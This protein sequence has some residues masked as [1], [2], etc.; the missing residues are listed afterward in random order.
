MTFPADQRAAAAG[1]SA[2]YA[3]LLERV[4]ADPSLLTRERFAAMIAAAQRRIPVFLGF[5]P[6]APYGLQPW[7]VLLSA[8]RRD[9]M[10]AASVGLARLMRALPGRLFGDDA[11]ALQRFYGLETQMLAMLLVA[12]PSGI[13]ETISRL[14][15][16]D[17]AEG[18]KCMEFNSGNSAA[19][20]DNVVSPVFLSEASPFADLLGEMGATWTDTSR[21]LLR[22]AVTSV[23][24]HPV[25][26]EGDLDLAV[27]VATHS[28]HYSK[29]NHPESHYQR[30]Y[31]RAL[32]ELAPGRRGRLHLVANDELTFEGGHLVVGGRRVRVVFGDIDERSRHSLF[33][34]L[35]AGSLVHL[36]SPVGPLVLGDKR[37]LAVLS[38]AAAKPAANPADDLLDD[39]ERQLVEHYIPWT[40]RAATDAVATFRDDAERPVPELLRR[41]RADLVLKGAL[42]FGGEDVVVGRVTEEAEWERAVETALEHGGWVVQEYLESVTYPL[43]LGDEGWAPHRLVWGPWV[44]GD[45]YAGLFVRL[46][47]EARGPVVNMVTGATVGMA[48]TPS[49]GSEAAA[50]AAAGSA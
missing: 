45:E 3:R 33:R 50:S 46:M 36:S 22:H 15:M 9:E 42:S 49:A 18:L 11:A 26:S 24:A 27:V 20:Q 38:A 19:W 47:P 39:A 4:E 37:N 6:A 8:E 5:D 30:Q 13:P 23:M 7:P 21:R 34:A 2:G 16:V 31:A 35:K 10:A 43:Q 1:L 17:T 32:A 25:G 48:F 28:S 41:H 44:A 29:D 40:R 14:D 12:E